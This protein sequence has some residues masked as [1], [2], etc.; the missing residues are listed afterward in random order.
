[1]RA[2]AGT[3][4][5]DGAELRGDGTAVRRR[6]AYAPGEIALYGELSGSDHLE[7]LLR[8]RGDEARRRARSIASDFGLPLERRVRTYSHGMKRQLLLAGA[9]APT[10]GSDPRR[11]RRPRPTRRGEVLERLEDDAA[12]GD[13]PPLLTPRRGRRVCRV[14]VFLSEGR[15][16]AESPPRRS[17]RA[18]GS[19]ASLKSEQ[20]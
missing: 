19:C 5:L 16:I 15:K 10:S 7:L 9:L 13:D 11:G 4:R 3:A 8:G 20:A 17:P 6:V 18:P 12:R 2:D 14:L 1:V